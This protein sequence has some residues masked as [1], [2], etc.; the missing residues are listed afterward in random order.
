[1]LDTS[2]THPHK[3][4]EISSQRLLEA[5]QHRRASYTS[6]L[7]EIAAAAAVDHTAGY[8]GQPRRQGTIKTKDG[9]IKRNI[10]AHAWDMMASKKQVS[11]AQWAA[12]DKLR[13]DWELSQIYPGSAQSLESLFNTPRVGPAYAPRKMPKGLKGEALEAWMADQRG[14]RAQEWRPMAASMKVSYHDIRPSVIDAGDRVNAVRER[15]I[16]RLDKPHWEILEAV[17]IHGET[18]ASLSR[19]TSAGKRIYGTSKTISKKLRA[20]VD[21]AGIFYGMWN[22][23]AVNEK[24]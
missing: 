7:R 21:V 4:A 20:G 15:V 16:A 13:L 2:A 6:L 11:V 23:S 5:L 8:G 3:D 17:C 12:G 14:Y 10:G 24:V 18:L 9:A 1:M 19:R 22:F